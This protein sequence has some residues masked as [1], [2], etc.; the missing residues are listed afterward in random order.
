LSNRGKNAAAKRHSE[1]TLRLIADL[2]DDEIVPESD[3]MTAA[4]MKALL[5][6]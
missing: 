4:E 3:G 1:V 2:G 6:R 5:A